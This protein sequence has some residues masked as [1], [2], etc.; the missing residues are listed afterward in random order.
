MDRR[1]RVSADLHDQ[2]IPHRRAKCRGTGKSPTGPTSGGTRPT[3]IACERQVGLVISPPPRR[4]IRP[5]WRHGRGARRPASASGR[6][7]TAGRPQRLHHGVETR[8]DAFVV[9]RAPAAGDHHAGEGSHRCGEDDAVEQAIGRQAAQRRVARIEH[10]QVGARTGLQAPA[11]K[12]RCH[13]AARTHALEQPRRG[14]RLGT[15]RG[16][17]VAPVQPRRWPYSSQ[18]SS[19]GQERATWLSE[20]IAIGTPAPASAAVGQAV[21][22]IRLGARAE[23][24]AGAACGDRVDLGR[25][26][27]GRVD[28]LPARVE[29]GLAAA[30]RSAGTG[31]GDAVLD[32]ARPARR[33]G[34]G[35]AG[36]VA[37]RSVSAA[38]DCGALRAANG[39]RRRR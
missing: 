31:R 9:H 21:A 37:D 11:C 19:S 3:C 35:S 13:G 16:R 33:R 4:T 8:R 29:R 27:V 12:A 38:I 5:S 2:R 34:C 36:V 32:L 26:R 15:R 25:R 10:E 7:R 39:S 1:P 20:P 22:E 18:R 14:R 30:I 23:H 24:D 17:H 28:Q 6:G